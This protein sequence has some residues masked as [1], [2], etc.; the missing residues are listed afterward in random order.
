MQLIGG[1]PRDHFLEIA[2][3]V[4]AR[5]LLLP[6]NPKPERTGGFI[7]V[8][9]FFGPKMLMV[10]E[11]GVC[12]RKLQARCFGYCQEKVRRLFDNAAK[13]HVSSWQSR[14]PDNKKYGGAITVHMYGKGCREAKDIIG[15]VSGLVEHGDEAVTLVIWMIF[16][17]LILSE[18]QAIADISENPLFRPLV[19]ACGDLFN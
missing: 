9:E 10:N 3:E 17:W 14:D 4:M 15:A 13:G 19:N 2:E 18:A 8:L 5:F 16:H 11:L 7:A 1:V 12:E 6:E